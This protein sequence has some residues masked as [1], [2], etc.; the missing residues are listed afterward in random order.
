MLR[1]TNPNDTH[2][3]RTLNETGLH[4]WQGRKKIRMVTRVFRSRWRSLSRW[5]DDLKRITTNWIKVIQDRKE[6]WKLRE[7]FVQQ[8]PLRAIYEEMGLLMSIRRWV[9]GN[10]YAFEDRD[11]RKFVDF[12]LLVGAASSS[13]LFHSS[14][15]TYFDVDWS[16]LR[17]CSKLL[18]V[19]YIW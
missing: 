19:Q 10:T 4:M 5:T 17:L 14:S 7:A 11:K 15:T 18:V 2:R 16:P 1:I 9:D 12:L 8:L 3:Q 6:W 13:L